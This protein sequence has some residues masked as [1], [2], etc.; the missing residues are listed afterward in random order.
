VVATE[1]RDLAQS[2]AVAAMEIKQLI[3]ISVGKVNAGTV[4]ARDAGGTMKEIITSVNSVTSIMGEISAASVEQSSGIGQVNQA[5]TQMDEVTQQ[6]AA[7]VEQ[8]SAA[9][10]ALEQQAGKLMQ[11]L[12]VFKLTGNQTAS[13]AALATVDASPRKKMRN[14]A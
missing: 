4:L 14:A 11:A 7:L 9:T 10:N 13:A 12:A 1:V 6:N 8:A 3:D 5:I 2:A